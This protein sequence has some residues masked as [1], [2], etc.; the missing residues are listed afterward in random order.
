VP[1]VSVKSSCCCARGDLRPV[2][3]TIKRTKIIRRTKTVSATPKLP[4]LRRR[5]WVEIA[6][7]APVEDSSPSLLPSF[8]LGH[9]L[10]QHDGHE[11]HERDEDNKLQARHLCQRYPAGVKLAKT[12]ESGIKWCCPRRKTTTRTRF[13]T[14]TVRKTVTKRVGL[15]SSMIE[16]GLELKTS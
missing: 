3:K 13:I 16:R 5:D 11:I 14:R 12:G 15:T 7:E 2:I 4:K 9:D 8:E 1:G 6:V 10:E